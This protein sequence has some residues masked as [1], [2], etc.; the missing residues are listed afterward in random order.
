VRRLA[1]EG[2]RAAQH[3]GVLDAG[4]AQLIRLEVAFVV[5][6]TCWDRGARAGREQPSR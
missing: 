2:I 5:N 3:P 4:R 1:L 6:G